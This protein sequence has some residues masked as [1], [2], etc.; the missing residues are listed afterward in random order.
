MKNTKAGLCVLICGAALMTGGAQARMPTVPKEMGSYTSTS[1]SGQDVPLAARSDESQA[2]GLLPEYSVYSQ[3]E[4]TVRH[5]HGALLQAMTEG[6]YQP[7]W[8]QMVDGQGIETWYHWGLNQTV[9]SVSWSTE[10]GYV[11]STFRQ[12]GRLKA[13]E[14]R[15]TDAPVD[16]VPT[17]TLEDALQA[18]NVTVTPG[19]AS[20]AA[21]VEKTYHYQRR[22]DGLLAFLGQR[23]FKLSWI[24]ESQSPSQGMA[25]A[26]WYHPNLNMTVV[27][28]TWPDGT[29]QAQT[30]MPFS[31]RL[32]SN[33]FFPQE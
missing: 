24:R 13:G 14:V 17:A 6:G 31:G 15:G 28:M 10:A 18:F 26:A 19:D 25:Y 20:N 22:H 9:M 3:N 27:C 11:Q 33:V 12:P 23:G 21:S 32:R 2:G 1:D 5:L 7:G 4:G 8:K 16:L 29:G 30:I